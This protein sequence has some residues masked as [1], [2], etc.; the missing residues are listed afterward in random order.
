M[1]NLTLGAIL[2]EVATHWGGREIDRVHCP[3]ESLFFLRLKPPVRF[4]PAISVA[5]SFAGV[6]PA[7]RIPRTGSLPGGVFPALLQKV[8]AG[9]VLNS[10]HKAFTERQVRFEFQGA[11]W[12]D[13]KGPA[14]LVAE[15]IGRSANLFLLRDNGRIEGVARV[16]RSEYRKFS[17]GAI[18]QGPHPRGLVELASLG[19]DGFLRLLRGPADAGPPEI[20]RLISPGLFEIHR[21][22]LSG[23][24]GGRL[25]EGILRD[26]QEKKFRPVLFLP[27]PRDRLGCGL[28]LDR[29]T[30]RLLPFP[31]PDPVSEAREDFPDMASAAESL[32]E[33]LLRNWSFQVEW[34]VARRAVAR[35]RDRFR[36]LRKALE[37]DLG[38][39]GDPAAYRHRGEALLAG[40]SRANVVS[41]VARVPDPY[42]SEGNRMEIPL[43]DP[44]L[45]LAKNAE[46]YFRKSSKAKRADTAIRDRLAKAETE[47]RRRNVL[48]EEVDS[49]QD[50]ES[51]RAL[52]TRLEQFGILRTPR[53]GKRSPPPKREFRSFRKVVSPEGWSIYIGRNARENQHLTFRIAKERD[54]W[55]HAAG[56]SG[57][58]VIVRNP[59]GRKELPVATLRMAAGAAAFYS[60]ARRELKVEVHL[61]FRKDVRRGREPGQVRL[62]RSRTVLARPLDPLEG[63]PV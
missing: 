27:I 63:K 1:D 52:S 22:R 51:L 16:L 32:L 35:E 57:S 15:L 45:G 8:L 33:V 55:L 12:S 31:V 17:P 62:K 49:V 20:L 34:R 38:R 40:I 60:G 11:G 36:R 24:E 2:A 59:T 6:F 7:S 48:L 21:E 23:A 9:S 18:Y 47:E 41:G 28:Q 46:I 44:A 53:K 19:P 42:S 37:G 3:L 58:H 54:F 50:E 61:A 25:V 14:T 39:V 43:Q 30:A 56:V 13:G 4:H 10:I 5:P 29:R 26:F